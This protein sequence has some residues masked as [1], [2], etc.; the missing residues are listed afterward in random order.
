MD[1]QS[2]ESL[3]AARIGLPP[4]SAFHRGTRM[5][6]S[7]VGGDILVPPPDGRFPSITALGAIHVG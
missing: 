6:P 4:S 1:G 3:T 2:T 5:S 7:R